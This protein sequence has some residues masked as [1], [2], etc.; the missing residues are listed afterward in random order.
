MANELFDTTDQNGFKQLSKRMKA[1]QASGW[2]AITDPIRR[3]HVQELERL[4]RLGSRKLD[5]LM[6][7]ATMK[8][9]TAIVDDQ[10][11]EITFFHSKGDETPTQSGRT[12][13]GI[14]VND[15]IRFLNYGTNPSY[16]PSTAEYLEFAGKYDYAGEYF[17]LKQVKGIEPLHFFKKLQ[18]FIKKESQFHTTTEQVWGESLVATLGGRK[19]ARGRLRR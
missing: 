8:G 10:K 16:G 18:K 9:W 14:T 19:I 6:P 12:K 17:K 7:R 13:E 1:Q 4:A 11:L 5:E 3:A 15:I 2:R